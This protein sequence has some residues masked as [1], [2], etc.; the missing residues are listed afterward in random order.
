MEKIEFSKYNGQGNDFVMLDLVTRKVSLSNNQI[1]SICDRHFGIGADGL[2]IVK[3]SKKYDFYMDYYN[4]D[5]SKAEMCGNG[6]R[7]MAGFINYRGLSNS[8]NI[9]IDTLAGNRAIEMEIVN[10]KPGNIKV[11]MGAPIFNPEDIPVNI[12]D[13][14]VSDYK[15]YTDKYEFNINCISMGNPHCV[16]YIDKNEGLKKIPLQ[17][18]GSEIENNAIFPNKTN[19]EFVKVID[20]NHI[21]MRIWERGVGETLAC[22]TGACAA[23]VYSIKLGKV[24]GPSINVK[25]PGGELSVIWENSSGNVFLKGRVNHV[26]EDR[27]SVV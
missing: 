15:L 17:S 4:M 18:W 11:D 5:G 8:N 14:E 12:E 20:K 3:K 26:F 2:I 9:T 1:N 27:K 13:Q 19:V 24:N 25:V 22:G 6:I 10:G 7:C 23:G 21:D 16:T